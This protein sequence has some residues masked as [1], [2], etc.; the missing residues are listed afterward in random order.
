MTKQIRTKAQNTHQNRRI[1]NPEPRRALHQQVGTHNPARIGRFRDRRR[2]RGVF[3]RVREGTDVRLDFVVGAKRGDG[4]EWLE[5][6][7]VPCRGGEEGDERADG[8]YS[9]ADVEEC[10]VERG[11][12]GGV[13]EG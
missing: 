1:H 7:A 9:G 11:V 12:N 13:H 10:G 8:V 3:K 5:D 6:E 4:G 2:A